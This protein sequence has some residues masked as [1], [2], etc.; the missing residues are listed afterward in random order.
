MLHRNPVTHSKNAFQCLSK[1]LRNRKICF[2]TTKTAEQFYKIN[3]SIDEVRKRLIPPHRCRENWMQQKCC[4]T[5]DTI[6]GTIYQRRIHKENRRKMT[7]IL[8]SRKK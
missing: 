3:P 2:E 4:S 6:N 1:I 7:L 8:K 5:G